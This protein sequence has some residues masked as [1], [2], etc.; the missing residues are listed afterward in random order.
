MGNTTID[1]GR[2]NLYEKDIE[3]WLWENPQVV[4][5]NY[6]SSIVHH[7]LGRQIEVPSGIIDLLGVTE[8][9]IVSVV[10]VK[11]TEINAKTLTQVCRYAAD[12]E[13]IQH[14]YWELAPLPPIFKTVICKGEISDRKMLFEANALNVIVQ[15]FKVRLSL[16]IDGLWGWTKEYSKDLRN[17]YTELSESE[18]FL[19]LEENAHNHIKYL[20]EFKKSIE[21]KSEV[22]EVV[23]EAKRII[24]EEGRDNER[25]Q[26]K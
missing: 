19:A 26:D 5:A 9:G 11:N 7:W 17:H 16:D 2:V 8:E 24:G 3:D 15:T 18:F 10:E 14:N 4:R 25:D 20:D 21:Q 23:E 6:I 12:I 22:S 1:P 13:S